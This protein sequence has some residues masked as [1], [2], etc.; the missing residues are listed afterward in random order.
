MESNELASW[1][2]LLHFSTRCLCVLSRGGSH[3]K[4]TKAF[5]KQ[6]EDEVDPDPGK[7]HGRKTQ[8]YIPAGLLAAHVAAKL[9]EGDFTGA[10]RLAC[11]EDIIA[12]R[13][14]ATPNAL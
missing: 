10:I 6:I 4:S 13:N 1:N 7:Q 8:K 14:K 12:D 11:S 5:K 9:E 3:Y 2:R